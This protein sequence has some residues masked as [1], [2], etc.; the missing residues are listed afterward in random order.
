MVPRSVPRA[1]GQG[2]RAEAEREEKRC[3]LSR[4]ETAQGPGGPVPE[5]AARELT[6]RLCPPSMPSMRGSLVVAPEC[7]RGE[8]AR[9]KGMVTTVITP[10][11]PPI[12]Y[13][14]EHSVCQECW[15]S[16]S[17]VSSRVGQHFLAVGLH[18]CRDRELTTY[19]AGLHAVTQPRAPSTATSTGQT[20]SSL[21]PSLRVSQGATMVA[22]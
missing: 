9:G 8:G 19:L 21:I 2:A 16:V 10:W 1:E 17:P 20:S 6:S 3:L 18:T 12:G 22:T 7:R 13:Q 5:R 4:G 15:A 14:R 11:W